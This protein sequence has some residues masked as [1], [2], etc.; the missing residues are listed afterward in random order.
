MIVFLL[1][2]LVCRKMISLV[3]HKACPKCGSSDLERKRRRFWMRLIKHSKRYRCMDCE[4]SFLYSEVLTYARCPLISF[5]I[6][7]LL[8]TFVVDSSPLGGPGFGPVEIA[9]YAFGAVITTL[10]LSSYIYLSS[11]LLPLQSEGSSLQYFDLN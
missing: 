10:A 6:A 7:F 11:R 9:G 4:Q 5:G 3:R 1:Y 2:M 8:F